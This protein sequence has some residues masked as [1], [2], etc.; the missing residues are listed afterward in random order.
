MNDLLTLSEKDLGQII[1]GLEALKSKDMAGELM[2]DMLDAM[3][4][5]KTSDM[6]PTELIQHEERKRK[7]AEQKALKKEKEKELREQID[8]LKAK[9]I[10]L[11]ET[12]KRQEFAVN[13]RKLESSHEKL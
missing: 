8:V 1:D 5:K 9:I 11:R 4:G 12:K 3:M 7:E 13:S 2:V 10:L 6:S